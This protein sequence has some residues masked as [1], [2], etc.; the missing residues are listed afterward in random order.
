M[1]QT[2]LQLLVYLPAV[3]IA[4][5][6]HEYAHGR[7]ADYLGDDTPYLMGRLTLNPLPHIDWIGFIMLLVFHFGW[8]KPVQVNPYRFKKVGVKKG[9]MFVAVAGPVMNL[10]L[11]FVAMLLLRLASPFQGS[12][13]SYY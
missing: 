5:T 4:L 10:F 2:I 3:L 9:M 13:W 7:A 12:E 6:F 1:S 11:A 8:A